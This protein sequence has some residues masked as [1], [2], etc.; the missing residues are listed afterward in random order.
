MKW[1]K[2]CSSVCEE[3]KLVFTDLRRMKHRI[4]HG[5]GPVAAYLAIDEII[6]VAWDL[7]DAITQFGLLSKSRLG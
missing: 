7:A 6:R 3:D 5:M 2:D 1:Q 4:G